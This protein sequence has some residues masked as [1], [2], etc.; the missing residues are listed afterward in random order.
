MKFLETKS[1]DWK[2]LKYK[3]NKP[4]DLNPKNRGTKSYCIVA[5]YKQLENILWYSI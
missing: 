3:Y 4:I 2:N 1:Y 5:M